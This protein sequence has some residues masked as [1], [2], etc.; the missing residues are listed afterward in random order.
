MCAWL[1][2][3]GISLLLWWIL[4]AKNRI[5]P[6]SGPLDEQAHLGNMFCSV[7]P[8]KIPLEKLKTILLTIKL[9]T[10]FLEER[11]RWFLHT[12]KNCASSSFGVHCS[13]LCSFMLWISQLTVFLPPP[14]ISKGIS[15]SCYIVLGVTFGHISLKLR[16]LDFRI[17][18]MI[19][20]ESAETRDPRV[21]HKAVCPCAEYPSMSWTTYV[22]LSILA[23]KRDV[24]KSMCPHS[25]FVL[26]FWK[27]EVWV[28]SLVFS[29]SVQF[30]EDKGMKF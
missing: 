25:L 8:W 14:L 5:K 3:F 21:C 28:Y 4:A 27:D 2:T 19:R 22:S 16:K 30:H 9:F 26:Y 29:L 13:P 17:W 18:N 11:L 12:H 23:S 7:C 20:V 10:F 24:F 6:S 15:S 1:T